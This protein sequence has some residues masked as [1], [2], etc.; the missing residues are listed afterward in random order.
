MLYLS[1]SNTCKKKINKPA[2]LKA[3]HIPWGIKCPVAYSI[4]FLVLV[5][6]SGTLRALENV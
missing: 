1:V 6:Y 2:T 5:G 3:I 4:Y